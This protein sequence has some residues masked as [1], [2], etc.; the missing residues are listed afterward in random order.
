VVHECERGHSI[1]KGGAGKLS[2]PRSRARGDWRKGRER[3]GW[4]RGN[5]KKKGI[6]EE[7][8]E[9]RLGASADGEG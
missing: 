7:D 1:T 2:Y 8:N 4:N 9:D 3:L 5:L 6:K